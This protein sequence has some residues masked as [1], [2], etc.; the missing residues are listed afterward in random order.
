MKSNGKM[1][2]SEWVYDKNYASYYYLT[3]E[4]SYARNTWVGNYYLK[5]NG[6]MAKSEWVDGGRYYVGANGLWETKSST[7]SEYPAALEK[8]K[9]YNSLFHMSK[10]HMY[11]QLTSQFDKFSNDA[12]QYAIDHLKTDYKYNALFNAKNY[13][14]LFNMSKSGLFNQL[15]S[16]IDGFTEEEANYAIQHLDD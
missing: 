6:K 8:A 16:Y 11:R 4:G 9:S 13:R 14:K 1:A 3:S 2:K 5:S 12:A 15:T 7:N 10:K